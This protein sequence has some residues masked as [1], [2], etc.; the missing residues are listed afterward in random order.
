[1]GGEVWL[2]QRGGQEEAGAGEWQGRRTCSVV[3]DFSVEHVSAALEVGL[4][5]PAHV[6]PPSFR[7]IEGKP[8]SSE[9]AALQQTWEAREQSC[10]ASRQALEG[11]VSML[12]GEYLEAVNLKVSWKR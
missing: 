11:E 6:T 10:A 3:D 8:V 5:A 12:L 2:V 4:R 7:D 1:M 9:S